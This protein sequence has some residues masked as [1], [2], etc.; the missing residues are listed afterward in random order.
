MAANPNANP[1]AQAA[2]RATT[3]CATFQINNAKLYASV[4]TMSIMTT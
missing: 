1:P 3:T 4:V 2:A